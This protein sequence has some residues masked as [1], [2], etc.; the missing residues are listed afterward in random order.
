MEIEYEKKY[1]IYKYSREKYL[2]YI[3]YV[4]CYIWIK[5]KFKM[6][7]FIKCKYKIQ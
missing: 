3:K 6:Y 1:K 2:E 7:L 4:L 5:L